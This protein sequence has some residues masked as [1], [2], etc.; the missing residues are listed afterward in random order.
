[1]YEK[2]ILNLSKLSKISLIL[3][4][5]LNSKKRVDDKQSDSIH[6]RIIDIVSHKR[7]N[8]QEKD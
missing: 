5:N 4:A 8:S 6:K 1:M 7:T 2:R 3:E